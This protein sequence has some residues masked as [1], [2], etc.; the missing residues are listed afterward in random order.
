MNVHTLARLTP[1]YA[2]MVALEASW[3]SHLGNG[4]M[5]NR[6]VGTET[7]NCRQNWWIN[8]IYLNNYIN[9]SKTVSPKKLF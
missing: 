2:V 9:L 1:A 3:F 7:E 6:L 5:W 8:L 4:P